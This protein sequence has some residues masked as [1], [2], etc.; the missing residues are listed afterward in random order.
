MGWP[1]AE[2]HRH[3][4]FL[5]L[6]AVWPFDGPFSAGPL[7]AP[8]FQL[9]TLPIL[10]EPRLWCDIRKKNKTSLKKETLR[11]AA[12][13]SEGQRSRDPAASFK[14]STIDMK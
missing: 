6:P 13:L 3:C 5:F 1:A 2:T 9:L 8:L 4:R 14:A 12:T 10:P 7:D 11:C